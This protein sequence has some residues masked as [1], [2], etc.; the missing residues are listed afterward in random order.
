MSNSGAMPNIAL[1]LTGLKVAIIPAP[2]APAAQRQA[3]ATL[4]IDQSG[5]PRA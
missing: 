4:T 5:G 2:S 3:W 1:E